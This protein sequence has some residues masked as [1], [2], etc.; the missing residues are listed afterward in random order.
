MMSLTFKQ[1]SKE[2]LLGIF[3]YIAR[4]DINSAERFLEGLIATCELL[5]KQ[6][7]MGARR[8][9]LAKHLRMF[10]HRKYCIYYHYEPNSDVVRIV[11]VLHPALDEARQQFDETG[12][13]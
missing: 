3:E 5:Q 10:V 7:E 8:N 6:P 11:R 4:D 2:D 13:T 9:D 1:R 12:S